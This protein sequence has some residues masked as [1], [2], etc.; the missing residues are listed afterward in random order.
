[1]AVLPPLLHFV[2]KPSE[3]S[4]AQRDSYFAIQMTW[5]DKDREGGREGRREEEETIVFIIIS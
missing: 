3:K 1:M 4:A 5:I 2:M